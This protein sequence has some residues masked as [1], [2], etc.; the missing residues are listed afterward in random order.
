MKTLLL[1]QLFI[2]LILATDPFKLNEGHNY[3]LYA[4]LQ[5]LDLSKAQMKFA[6]RIY[7]RFSPLSARPQPNIFFSPVSVYTTLSMLALGARSKTRMKILQAMS[8]NDTTTNEELNE[9]NRK[10][11][12]VVSQQTK[13]VEIKLGNEIFIDNSTNIL[14]EYQYNVARYYNASIQTISFSDPQNAEKAINKIVSDRADHKIQNVVSDLD[15]KKSMVLLD[16]VV[17]RAKWKSEF[18]KQNTKKRNFM[19]NEERP[20]AVPMMHRRRMYK[21]YKDK[22][23]GCKV[24]EAPYSGNISLLIIVPKLGDVL[25]MEQQLTPQR[26]KKYLRSMKTSLLDLYIP[27]VSFN[28]PVNVAYGLLDMEM[29][30]MGSDNPDFSG[31]SEKEKLRVSAF[32]HQPSI[33]I[34]EGGTEA[35]S[36]TDAQLN[37]AIASPEFK[38]DH[39]FLVLLYHKVAKII[40]GM[41]RIINPLWSQN[42]HPESFW[43]F[44]PSPNRISGTHSE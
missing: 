44:V 4:K 36:A 18:E 13:D 22:E 6:L 32:I 17:F 20:I 15:S 2:L 29:G 24:V 38:V 9:G 39:P 43:N 1:L 7:K 25:H 10:L 34:D 31:I 16:Y 40:L 41:G 12:Q 42:T 23:M 21:T 19:V 33:N 37:L 26:L 27:K 30:I 35:S 8:L 28:T 3:N 11:I 14:L 5:D